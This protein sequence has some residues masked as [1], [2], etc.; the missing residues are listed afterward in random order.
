[1]ALGVSA[2]QVA[3]PPVSAEQPEPLASSRLGTLAFR[4]AP[5]LSRAEP[6]EA[7][8]FH[9]ETFALAATPRQYGQP[10]TG[11]SGATA[12]LYWQTP[13]MEPTQWYTAPGA[14]DPATG[15]LTATWTPAMDVG[16]DRVT[17]F[18]ALTQGDAV[19]YRIHGRLRL[20]ASPGFNPAT[21]VPEDVRQELVDAIT[22]EVKDWADATYQPKGDYLTE[23]ADPTVSAWAKAAAK[24]TYAWAEIQGRP[25][26]WAWE[27]ITGKP[28]TFP[29]A[30]H[31]HDGSYLKLTGGTMTG[32]IL[33]ALS[34]ASDPGLTITLGQGDRYYAKHTQAGI[35]ARRALSDPEEFY[36]FFSVS[37]TNQIARLGDLEP[38]ATKA[39]L[40]SKADKTH[41]H[42]QAQVT[43]LTAALSQKANAT[44]THVAADITNL[45]ATLNPLYA[46]KSHAHPIA[47]VDGLQA[48]LNGKSPVGHG[49][50]MVDVEGLTDALGGYLS[51]TGGTVTGDT[52]IMGT[53]FSNNGWL[54]ASNISEGGTWIAAKYAAKSHTHTAA[55]ITEADPTVPAWAKAAA[56][57]TYA[58]AEIQGRPTSWA[59]EA[60]T[61]KPSAFPPAAHTHALADVTGLQEALNGKVSADGGFMS[62][63]LY[64]GIG[65]AIVLNVENEGRIYASEYYKFTDAGPISFSAL[66]SPKLVPGDNVTLTKQ[67]DGTVKV[68]A[69][70]GGYTLPVAGTSTIGGVKVGSTLEILSDGVLN[71]HLPTASASTK[72]GVKV[73]G[74]ESGIAIRADGTL[75]IPIGDGLTI[76]HRGLST[77]MHLDDN[78]GLLDEGM[79]VGLAPLAPVETNTI[80]WEQRPKN[81]RI[82]MLRVTPDA[83]DWVGFITEG[84]PEGAKLFV[85]LTTPA[86]FTLPDF[87]KVL[88]YFD[89]EPSSTYQLEAWVVAGTMYLSPILKEEP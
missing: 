62:G 48:E 67:T 86:A 88:G 38:L 18:L 68:S 61:G 22:G 36:A 52:T 10:L 24:P 50:A 63:S 77:T 81:T 1:M 27:A 35:Q 33:S 8:A 84:W 74:D 39:A 87:V 31:T 47:E 43:G 60:I 70:G 76:D 29:P 53:R 71:Y 5:E 64:L 41:T 78:G 9:S 69:T 14:Y 57:P 75:E 89:L 20:A 42:T 82:S 30:E 56:K 65:D 34:K 73:G 44:H 40:A 7:Q 23:E 11:L 83:S 17:F 80:A 4:W 59:W 6:Y 66:Y 37:G 26:S 21:L 2:R 79:G 46:A 16:G 49:H 15:T 13:G 55:Q 12:K 28:A 58:W 45:S 51:L 32:T 25:T 54:F 19:A 3:Q 72:G 85:R